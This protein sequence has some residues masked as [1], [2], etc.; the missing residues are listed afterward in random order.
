MTTQ[1]HLHDYQY[2]CWGL[3]LKLFSVKP[4][5]LLLLSLLLFSIFEPSSIIT[6]VVVIVIVVIIIIII[7][8]IIIEGGYLFTVPLGAMKLY[9]Q[10]NTTNL[11]R[12]PTSSAEG[13]QLAIHKFHFQCSSVG[14][15]QNNSSAVIT[16]ATHLLKIDK[17]RL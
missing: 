4:D 8:I 2:L 7:I 10:T 17:G 14:I 9:I 12:I 3:I 11:L 13:D 15:I 1:N 6:V 5:K 16:F